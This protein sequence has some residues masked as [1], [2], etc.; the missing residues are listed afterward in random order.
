MVPGHPESPQRLS[1]IEDQLN[2][3]GIADFLVHV[4]APR[5]S[6]SQLERVHSPGLIDLLSAISPREGLV[7]VD[8]D[9]AMNQYTLEAA[10][11]AAGA[12]VKAVEMVM[13]KQVRNAF[14]C[15]RPPGHHAERKQ[16]MGFC[17]FN[18]IAVA[19]ASA[20]EEHGLERVAI[21]DFDVHHGNG[22]EDIF[23]HDNRVLVCSSYQHP[24]YPYSGAPSIPGHMVN[25]PLP[26]G[27]GSAAYRSAIL[28]TW[29]P[30]LEA[31]QPQMVLI[32]A[33]FDAHRE[34]PLAGLC[35]VDADYEWL[36]ELAMNVADRYAE[37]RIVS[38][39]EGGYSLT[40]LS[41]CVPLH[42]RKLAAL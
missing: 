19:A 5:A 20:L 17:F 12:A 25:V 14:C 18:N 2:R 7:Q 37:G 21:L 4:E 33:G 6:R 41:R 3:L 22:T 16:A 26:E 29:L 31:F 36:T 38:A 35:L 13:S 1:A 15:V 42:I 9:T 39:L 32:S 11:R 27:T 23:M 10:W 40:A 34:D 8:P 24:L 28:E 30:E